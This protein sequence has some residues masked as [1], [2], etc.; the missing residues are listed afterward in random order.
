[1][2]PELLMDTQTH[3]NTK[4][5]GAFFKLFTLNM[6]K[7]TPTFMHAFVTHDLQYLHLDS[8][9]YSLN[10]NMYF[11]NIKKSLNNIILIIK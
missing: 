10:I 2:V 7:G 1:V 8:T 11:P 9:T 5:T 4:L 6:Q 3:G